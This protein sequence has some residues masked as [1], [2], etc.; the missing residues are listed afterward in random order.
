MK[1]KLYGKT[2]IELQSI[3]SNLGLPKFTAKQISDWL[4]KKHIDSIDEMSNLSKKARELLSDNFEFGIEKPIKENLST[5][6]TKKYLYKT[7]EGKFIETAYIPD[8]NRSTICVSS[9]VG[10]KM[11]CLFCSTG[12]QGFQ[13]DL[14]A[15]EILNQLHSLPEFE[16]ITNIVYMGMGEPF[17]NIENV[18]KSLEI[19]TSEY[20]YAMSPKRITVS[21]IGLI[22]GMK[23]FLEQTKANLAISM[24]SPFEEERKL[25]IPVQNTYSII[26]VID[27]IKSVEFN[28]QRRVSFEY[29]VFKN[30]N[31]TENHAKELIK[32]VK[33]LKCRVNLIRYHKVPGVDLETTSENNLLKF[34]NH[35]KAKGIL[36]TIRASRGQD[37]DAACG[38]LS[39]KELVKK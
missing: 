25:L 30:L 18:L 6:G 15:N 36:T 26:D 10:C 19:L 7:G 31:D 8:K 1:D 32:I 27:E 2:Q 11:N 13:A 17:D 28:S 14:S 9:Q 20:G 39:T 21:S 24:H 29:I 33:G 37:I 12:K 34:Q 3:V 38:L 16:K 35:L 4:Y 22:P 5:D 23:K